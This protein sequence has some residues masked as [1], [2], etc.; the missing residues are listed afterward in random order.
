MTASVAD[1]ASAERFGAFETLLDYL[2]AADVERIRAAYRFADQAHRGQL[3]HGGDPYITHPLAVASLCAD[4]KLDPPA[5]MA[6]LLH[7]VM[8][9]C[10]VAKAQIAE[11]FG[12]PVAELVDGLTKLDKLQFH[13]R[14]E[15]QAESFRKMLLAM[16]RDVRVILVKLADRTHNMRTMG[17][18]PR[19]KWRRIAS[20]T[21]EVYAPI[22]HR[23][24]FNR[25]YNELQDLAFRY[26]QP[27]RYAVLEKAAGKAR[28]RRR[29]LIDTVQQAVQNALRQG[30]LA[31]RVVGQDKTLY[32]IYHA[33]E[34]GRRSFAQVNDVYNLRVILPSAIQCYTALGLLHQL[35]KPVP[36]R[37]RDH[38]AI[39]KVNGYQSLHTTVVGPASLALELQIR[40]DLMDM[41][42]E[43][44][45]TAHWL[46]Q[47]GRGKDGAP[48]HASMTAPIAELGTRWL[49]SLLDIQDETQDSTEF[50]D[51]VKVD[52]FPDAIYVFTPKGRV[53]ALPQG[54]TPVDFAYAI[55]SDIGDHAV[56][57]KVNGEQA[58]MRAELANGD[59]VEIIT[60][61]IS[62]P[63]PAWLGF[64]RTGRA[65]SKIRHHL[66][67]LQQDQSRELGERLL[68]QALRAEGLHQPPDKQPE[69]TPV[70]DQLA[71]FTGSPSREDMLASIGLGKCSASAVAKHMVSLLAAQGI[72]P[73]ALLLTR[74]RYT[75][76][77]HLSQGAVLLDGAQNVSIGYAGCCLPVPGDAVVGYLG[78]GDGLIVHT[79]DCA[80]ARRLRQKDAE[81]FVTVAWADEPARAFETGVIVTLANET[82]ALARV[83]M[84]LARLGVS[85]AHLSMPDAGTLSALDLRIVIRVKD[86]AQLETVL[87]ALRHTPSVSRAERAQPAE[88]N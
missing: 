32:A 70:W 79:E 75:A 86:R 64:V 17:D 76:H 34:D 53:L 26:L 3:R 11:R 78:R 28:G 5:L 6:A 27:W 61:P 52:L 69:Q 80:V 42:A 13:T 66:K 38:I 62:T 74:E 19:H 2:P 51:N 85:I 88:R 14:E 63:N 72:K 12:A 68:A 71:R 21:R 36:G 10:G 48:S 7:D 59:V 50:W 83:T 1:G 23:L 30:E 73:D 4:W 40:T 20:E 55:H 15:G 82:G 47:V 49:Q 16:A 31:A 58:P 24:G 54:A 65:R 37:F 39:P 25:V 8:E 67:N 22:A 46:Y 77:E 87:R 35:Y 33:M 18:M 56:A 45:V 44:G 9:D 60:A 57:A 84:A 81:R 41:V 43:S 29:E